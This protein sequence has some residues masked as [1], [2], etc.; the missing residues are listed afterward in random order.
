[1]WKTVDQTKYLEQAAELKDKY[2]AVLD[3]YNKQKLV[4]A[5]SLALEP[6]IKEQNFEEEPKKTKKREKKSAPAEIGPAS[7]LLFLEFVSPKKQK[8]E[9]T[10]ATAATM[11]DVESPKV[12][13]KKKKKTSSKESAVSNA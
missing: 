2:G 4:A 7:E 13:K 8:I 3:S 12:D 10:D 1:M 11:T 9:P 5:S 6:E